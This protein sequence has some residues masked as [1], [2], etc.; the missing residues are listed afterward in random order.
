MYS[1]PKGLFT[2]IRV[3][4]VNS[5]QIK[6]QDDRLSTNRTRCEQGTTVRQYDGKRWYYSAV[7]GNEAEV[8]QG[9]IDGLAAIA[10]PNHEIEKDPVVQRLEAN[11][12][13][14][15]RF[16]KNS[17]TAI[18][19]E[20]KLELLRSYAE[21]FKDYEEIATWNI[22]YID[23]HTLKHIVSSKGADIIFDIQS[24][25]IAPRATINVNGKPYRAGSDFYKSSF[26][27]LFGHEEELRKNI[28]DALYFAKN[29]VPVEPGEYTCV[30][31]PEVAGVFAHESF[32]HK[33]EADFMVGDEAMMKEWK[34]GSRV[35][36][37]ML[38]IRDCGA[39]EG[40]GYVPYDDEGTRAKDNYLIKN[41][42]L[43]GRLHSGN[44]AAAL[45]EGLTGNA[46]AISFEYEPIVRMTTTYID[47]GD[48]TK[49]E[50]FAGVERGIY[51]E[52]YNHGSGMSTFTIAPNRAYMIEHGK[53]TTP[54]K[55]SVITGNVMETLSMVDGLSNDV[56]LCSFGLGG[57]GKMEQHS[58]RVGF[59]GP[60]VRV[61]GIK[62]Q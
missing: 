30:F 52:D 31:S 51:I 61:K 40:S 49:E 38:S 24:C 33:S 58:L 35:G 16:E 43:A 42:I 8:V 44:T 53:K 5:T 57:C 62:V 39:I 45:E 15:L 22:T 13:N 4:T 32:G 6:L 50:L 27:D 1:F 21:I 47:K 41:G 26:D 54:V 46:R 20:K 3:E 55:I 29:A 36:A 34:I 9:E 37:D 7:S 18:P 12:G 23:N 19:N 14:E 25:C 10:K 59:G 60:Y 2:D 11:R 48:L 56:E 28:E 17:V